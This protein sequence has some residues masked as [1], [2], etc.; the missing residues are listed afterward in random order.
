MAEDLGV[1]GLV[2]DRDQESKI[3][4]ETKYY[5]DKGFCESVKELDDGKRKTGSMISQKDDWF[6]EVNHQINDTNKVNALLPIQD[7]KINL[8][9]Q[10]LLKAS[11]DLCKHTQ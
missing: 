3:Q 8:S 10:K 9:N 5:V 4:N 6:K 11:E 7:V 1:E 2:M